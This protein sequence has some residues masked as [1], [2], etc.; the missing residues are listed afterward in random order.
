MPDTLRRW[1]MRIEYDGTPFVGWQ[2]QGA[3][4]SVQ[5]VVEAAASRLAG[6]APVRA[7]AAGRTDAGVHAAGQVVGIDLP[8]DPARPRWTGRRLRDA[9]NFHTKPHPVVVIEAEEAPAGWHPRFTATGRAYR[10]TVLNRRARPALDLHRAWHISRALD[11]AAMREAAALLEGRHD[12]TSFRASSCQAKSPIRTLDR[13]AV[14]RA[15]E[16]V[17]IEADARSFLH[18]QVRNMVGTLVLVGEGKWTP[19]DVARALEARDRRAA[20]PTAPPGG[21]CLLRVDYPQELSPW[22]QTGAGLGA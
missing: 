17:A 19:A 16:G 4:L 13:L 20:G 7:V 21:L 1:A 18:H 2:R 15:G 14:E 3:G 5:A 12:F 6:G 9:L 11:L 8:D 22:T 10:Y